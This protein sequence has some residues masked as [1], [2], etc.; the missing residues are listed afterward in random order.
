MDVCWESGAG[1]KQL[2]EAAEKAFFGN[3]GGQ[4]NNADVAA[5]NAQKAALE[6]LVGARRWRRQIL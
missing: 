3:K 1:T 6:A 4:A 2:G 5:L